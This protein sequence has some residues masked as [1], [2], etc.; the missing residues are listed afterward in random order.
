MRRGPLRTQDLRRSRSDLWSH[1]RRLRSNSQLRDL[2]GPE[3][4]WWRGRTQPMRLHTGH[5][6]V[7]RKKLRDHRRPMRRHRYLSDY[8][9]RSRNVRRRR[10]AQRLWMH[11]GHV[12]PQLLWKFARRLRGHARLRHL[13]SSEL[14]RRRR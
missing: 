8:L 4:L 13:Q 6:R 3:H 9:Q 2:Q 7:A 10:C 12:S 1:L 11:A 5:L 14:V